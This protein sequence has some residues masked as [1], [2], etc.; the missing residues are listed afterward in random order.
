MSNQ[1]MATSVAGV[2][3]AVLVGA[4]AAQAQTAAPRTVTCTSTAVFNTGSNG[5]GGKLALSGTPDPSWGYAAAAD[6]A[7]PPAGTTW[8]T[9]LTGRLAIPQWVWTDSDTVSPEAQWLTRDTS[10]NG[11]PLNY[12]RYVFN[13]DAAV[14]P[15]Q[16]SVTTTYHVDDSMAAIYINGQAQTPVPSNGWTLPDPRE[17]LPQTITL[18][19]NWVTGTNEVILVAANSGN[20]PSGVLVNTSLAN[21]ATVAPPVAV[22]TLETWSLGALAAL[23]ATGTW[24]GRR[25]RT[26]SRRKG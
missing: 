19:N 11:V 8:A 21:C 7:Y 16:F 15:A 22:P 12:Y 25:S 3:F 23:M 9:P 13:L 18:S 26:R 24:L 5:A 14:D 10:L 6:T 2:L 4:P 1:S 20:S 17:T